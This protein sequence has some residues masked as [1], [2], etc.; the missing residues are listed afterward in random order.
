MTETKKFEA[1]YFRV[2]L[3]DLFHAAPILPGSKLDLSNA[4]VVFDELRRLVYQDGKRGVA[5]A[6]KRLGRH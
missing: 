1:D 5:E 2:L 3:D 4:G 6:R